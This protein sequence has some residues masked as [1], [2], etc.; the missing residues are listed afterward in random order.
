ME[1]V[2][3]LAVLLAG[4]VGQSRQ[5]IGLA[6]YETLLADLDDTVPAVDCNRTLEDIQV[7]NL[8]AL[9]KNFFPTI[10]L[11]REFVFCG[12]VV[13]FSTVQSLQNIFLDSIHKY[14]TITTL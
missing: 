10:H 9:C 13:L 6:Q 3:L 12:N 4:V 5:G 8:L 7:R 11:R 1:R 2:L 14:D